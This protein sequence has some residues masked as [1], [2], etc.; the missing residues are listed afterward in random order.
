MATYQV[1]GSG[2]YVDF[3]NCNSLKDQPIVLNQHD[4]K[5]IFRDHLDLFPF[6]DEHEAITLQPDAFNEFV[7]RHGCRLIVIEDF[8]CGDPM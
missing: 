3:P 8:K 5:R 1:I 6:I 4:F 2:T 7:Q